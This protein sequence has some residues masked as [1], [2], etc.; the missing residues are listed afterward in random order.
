MKSFSALGLKKDIVD[1]LT[2]LNFK[3]PS[4]VQEKIIPL[5][6]QG[7]NVVFTSKTGSGKTLTYL[8]GYLGKINKK[9]DLQMIVLVPTRELCIQVGKEMKKLCE[10]LGIK[11]GM[12]YGGR[13]VHGDFK[14]TSKKNHV[15][16]GTP[17]RLIQHINSRSLK[18]GDVKYLV[19]D[20]CDHMFDDGFFDQCLYLKKRVSKNAQIILASATLSNRVNEFRE[21]I[22]H[23]LIDIGEQV[24]SKIVQRKIYC[25]IVDKNMIL[26]NFLRN[27]KFKRCLI[28]CNTK[29]RSNQ[30]SDFLNQ[31]KYKTKPLNASLTQ[32]ERNNTLNLFKQAKVSI[33]V[34]TNIAARGLQIKNVDIVVNYDVAKQ[35]EFHVHRIGRTGRYDKD[36]YALTLICPEDEKRFDDIINTYKMNIK[37]IKIKEKK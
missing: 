33:L 4:E 2:R 23:E 11:I 36:G 19:Y 13:T 10:P 20:E 12:L 25:K 29:D 14:T 8:L 17:G 6:I 1:V 28:F 7:K 21:M 26:V 34:T 31:Y 15:I 5:E 9:V 30:I 22:D 18:A 35:P 16:I 32:D 37:E 3:V 24:P 27:R